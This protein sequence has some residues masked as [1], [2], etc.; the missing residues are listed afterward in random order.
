MKRSRTCALLLAAFFSALPM[1]L[2]AEEGTRISGRILDTQGGLP[3]PNAVIELDRG[4]MNPVATCHPELVEGRQ[5]LFAF[6]G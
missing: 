2:F 4:G 6:A 3:V 1:G 5:A